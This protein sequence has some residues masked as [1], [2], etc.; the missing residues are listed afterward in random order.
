MLQRRSLVLILALLT[1]VNVGT[2]FVTNT[3]LGK[4][5][6]PSSFSSSI[7]TR[8]GIRLQQSNVNSNEKL[9]LRRGSTVALVTPILPDTG[10]IDFAS[11]DKLLQYHI[12]SGTDNLCVLGTTGEASSF[13]REER[14]SILS[15]VVDKVKGQIPI[16][17][18]TGTIDTRTVRERSSEASDLGA[19]AALIVTPYYVKPPQRC[20]IRHFLDLADASMAEQGLPIVAYNVPGRTAVNFLDE[21]IATVAQHEKIVGV[22]DATGDVSRVGSLRQHL[23]EVGGQDL[24]DNFLVYSG[25][26]SSSAE[27][28]LLGGS[29]CISVTANVA[30]SEMHDLMMLA[31]EGKRDEAMA[32][33]E[34]LVGLHKNLFCEANPI[35]VKWACHELG[36]IKSPNCRPPL[37]RLDPDLESKVMDGLKQAKL[38]EKLSLQ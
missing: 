11:L 17:V 28:C 36:L 12:D 1:V 7:T 5:D 25:E 9:D 37:D 15:A 14:A 29:G 16:L 34:T 27:H 6:H 19:D 21:N 30:A 2:A 13:T 20:L 18:G 3:F 31:M 24:V 10:K 32:L 22:K 26:D 4:K 38:L 33:D 8:R 23:L 35:P